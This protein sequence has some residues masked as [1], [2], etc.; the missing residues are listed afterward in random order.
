MSILIQNV[1]IMSFKLISGSNFR[2][3]KFGWLMVE[4]IS[5]M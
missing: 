4:K 3:E 1:R 2:Y 5:S